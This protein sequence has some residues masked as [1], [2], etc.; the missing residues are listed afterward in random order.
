MSQNEKTNLPIGISLL[1]ENKNIVTLNSENETILE[2]ITK[3]LEADKYNSIVTMENYK[4]MKDSSLELGKTSKFISNFRIAKKKEE[5]V[6]IDEFE[7]N[8]KGYCKLIDEKQNEIKSGLNV[9]EEQTRQK[10]LGVCKEYFNQYADEV[11]L[12]DE[13]KTINLDDMT[14]TKYATATFNI[15]KTGKDEVEKR[16]NEKLALQNK[17][18][19]RLM[20]LENECL[21]NG[22]APMSKEYIQGFLYSDDAVYQ[23][24]L[25]SL[26]Q[27]EIKRAEQEKARIEQVAQAKVEEEYRTKYLKEQQ[28]LKEEV[29][30]ET[31]F[32]GPK[33]E[34]KEV[35]A[36]GKVEKTLSIK[37]R[38]PVRATDEQVI[39]AVINMIKTD[40]FPIENI[41]VN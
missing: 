28:A 25:N 36:D 16:V 29:K 15:S 17:V 19:M 32:D 8:L 39:G 40:R 18:D 14:L 3:E 24:K 33:E 23:E 4:V 9:F 26:I 6:H 2:Q 5:M 13:F 30:N 34:A 38:V 7:S 41:E 37:I 22:I 20:N 12:R 21:K 1:D 27:I 35:A 11:L 10:V 31:P